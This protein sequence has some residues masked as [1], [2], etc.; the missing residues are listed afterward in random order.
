MA[1]VHRLMAARLAKVEVPRDH[2][3][4]AQWAGAER[5]RPPLVVGALRH[6]SHS[7]PVDAAGYIARLWVL[8]E[9]VAPS[10]HL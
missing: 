9:V 2:V 4:L 1:N 6:L 8:N 3:G 10:H 7:L 5:A